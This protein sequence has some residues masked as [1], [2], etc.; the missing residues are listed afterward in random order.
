MFKNKFLQILQA[1]GFVEKAKQNQL[2]EDEWKQID[3]AFKKEFGK[4]MTELMDESKKTE[5]LE[6]DRAAALA[7]INASV[8]SS[9]DE[10]QEEVVRSNSLE[11]GVQSIVAKIDDVTAQNKK[12][13]E[14]MD[15]MAKAA[16]PDN[17]LKVVSQKLSP[18]GPG[19]TKT[20][21]FGIE[22]PM[23]DMNKRWNQITINPNVAKLSAPNDEVFEAFQTATKTYG[24]S[25]AQRYK[26]LKD[27]NLLD[28]LKK[29]ASFTNDL[30]ELAGAGLG[31]QYV[32]LRQDALIA[33]IA[34]I[35][36]VY[37]L[38]PRRYGVQDRELMTIAYFEELSQGYQPGHVFKGGMKLQPEMGY[39]DTAMFKVEFGPMDEIERQYIGYLNTDG[40]DPMKWSM[41]EWQLLNMYKVLINEQN[42]RVIR[43]CFVKPEVGKP[44]SFLNAGT[45]LFYT[46]LRYI[47]ENKLLP[48]SD[49][50]YN[51]YTET[52][53]L[54]AVQAFIAD[55]EENPE[56]DFSLDNKFIY[57]NKRH[58]SW[59]IQCI[60]TKFGKDTDFSGP[61][62]YINIVPDHSIRIKWV[63]NMGNSK[64]MFIQE[65]GNLQALEFI[66]GEMLA[67]SFDKAMELYHVW[68][69]WKEGFSGF[70]VGKTFDS[71][72]ALT[73]NNRAMQEIFMNH[74]ATLLDA[75]ATTIDAATL[76]NFWFLTGANAA[77]TALTDISGAKTGVV[78]VIEVG[79]AANA[80][81]I[82]KAGKFA[83][84]TAAWNPS[85]VGDYIMVTL[86]SDGT[87]AELERR[88]AGIRTINKE[89]QPN[90]PG[91][92]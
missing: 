18:A 26:F 12:L 88:V 27:N 52:T 46:L 20:H 24:R 37:D 38:F 44:G 76:K 36:T 45:G 33:R 16:L 60:R 62:S 71:L 28:P 47:H 23:F 54:D 63:P 8:D 53:M 57:L 81:T 61:D 15:K 86:R 22:N 80:T 14:Q 42:I 31:D 43:G 69:T 55:V 59:W 58:Q 90:I 79:T 11:T 3:E 85:S 78:Y 9:A 39:V 17:P 4:S 25:L 6:K 72:S 32:T 2:S 34:Q 77:P 7:I 50:A 64:L 82:A 68:S 66:P 91:G 40:S 51:D 30:T 5:E 73:A 21:L 13:Q 70:I 48:H 29:D 89:L 19:H 74:P 84:I 92:R 67:V 83:N 41:I 75:G 87:F 49:P 65:H 56:D 35:P 10:S 1:L